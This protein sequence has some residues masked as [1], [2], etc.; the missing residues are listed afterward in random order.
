MLYQPGLTYLFEN[1]YF[2][3]RDPREPQETLEMTEF[4]EKM[5]A[6]D[7]MAPRELVEFLEAT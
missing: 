7:L 6:R 1:F 3:F 2:I 5:E 4:V